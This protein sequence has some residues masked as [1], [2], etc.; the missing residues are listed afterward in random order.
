MSDE[1]FVFVCLGQS[2]LLSAVHGTIYFVFGKNSVKYRCKMIKACQK[3]LNRRDCIASIPEIT[4]A[5]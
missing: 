5:N 2:L 4:K 1:I 3:Q